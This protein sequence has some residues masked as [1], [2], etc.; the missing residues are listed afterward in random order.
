[1]GTSNDR[2][3]QITKPMVLATC[4][5]FQAAYAS[6]SLAPNP[7][8]PNN[9]HIDYGERQISNSTGRGSEPDSSFTV[10]QAREIVTS[11]A[12]RMIDQS[13][14]LPSEFV[15]VLNSD[16]FWDMPFDV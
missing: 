8:F 15:S 7:P 14:E 10:E 9:A 4:M 3:I 13:S 6:P 5:G 16:D 2:I 1:M 12:T 11:F